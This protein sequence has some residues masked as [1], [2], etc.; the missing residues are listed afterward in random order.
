[1]QIITYNTSPF[2]DQKLG[3]SGL[4][5][6]VRVFKQAHYLENFVQSIF[7]SLDDFQGKS[8]V[9]GGMADILTDRLSKLSSK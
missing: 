3:T 6:K 1:M 8:L 9:L 5:K 2:D 4:R 7:N